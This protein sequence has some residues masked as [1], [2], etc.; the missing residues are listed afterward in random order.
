MLSALVFAL[1]LALLSLGEVFAQPGGGSDTIY[2]YPDAKTKTETILKTQIV[3]ETPVGIT[4]KVDKTEIK[5]IPSQNIV[6]ISYRSKS[7]D[8]ST[9]REGYIKE[10][11]AAQ[12]SRPADRK[13]FLNEALTKFK[14]LIPQVKDNPN[15]QRY[16]EWKSADVKARLAD[17]EPDNKASAQTAIE[18]LTAFGDKNPQS[19]EIVP[20]MMELSQLQEREGN[21][22]AARKAH[23]FLTKIPNAPPELRRASELMIVQ[24]YLR[25]KLYAEA[26]AKLNELSKSV[27]AQDPQRDLIGLYLIETRIAQNKL[28]GVEPSLKKVLGGAT[29][30]RLLAL[31]HTSLGDY[32]RI[33]KQD[34]EALWEYLKVDAL[35]SQEK[36]EHAKALYWL[37]RLFESVQGNKTRAGQCLERLLD[38]TY[39]GTEYQR[40]VLGDKPT[41]P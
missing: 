20:C 1:T 7:I 15:A 19:W 11:K 18:A 5:I 23:E 10:N 35:Y 38:K 36:E 34:E 31:A 4:V 28:D 26:E 39:V 25:A 21:L 9:F 33:K 41:P 27:S 6:W 37:S 24:L 14:E 22:E 3:E 40:K 13:T 16:L 32:Y 30:P 17:L 12:A 8:P 29:E 2:Y